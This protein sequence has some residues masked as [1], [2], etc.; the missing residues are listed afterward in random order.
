MSYFL[1]LVAA[2]GLRGAL[3]TA[4]PINPVS[5]CGLMDH[6]NFDALHPGSILNL[7]RHGFPVCPF[8]L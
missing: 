6:S 4:L 8:F 5:Y 2:P 1:F 7:D 3:G